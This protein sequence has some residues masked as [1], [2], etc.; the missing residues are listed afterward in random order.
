[1]ILF[2]PVF[3][4]LLKFSICYELCAFGF[5]FAVCLTI[6]ITVN[7]VSV[8]AALGIPSFPA[9]ILSLVN[10]FA[11]SCHDL[12]PCSFYDDVCDGLKV[13]HLLCASA[14]YE[15]IVNFFRIIRYWLHFQGIYGIMNRNKMRISC[16]HESKAYLPRAIHSQNPF[17]RVVH[18]M[19]E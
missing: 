9:S 10:I 17:H 4:S 6:H 1:M 2:P 18:S 12:P 3:L 7:N 15:L 19:K 14:V 8:R 16:W 5:C 13:L 11:S